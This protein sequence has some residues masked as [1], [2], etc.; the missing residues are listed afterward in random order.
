MNI[1]QLRET[2]DKEYSRLRRLQEADENGNVKCISCTKVTNWR[3]MTV[4]HYIKRNYYSVRYYECNVNP[5]CWSCQVLEES[6]C[7]VT[8]KKHAQGL[9]EKY[10]DHILNTLGKLKRN[11]AHYSKKDYEDMIKSFRAEIRKLKKQKYGIS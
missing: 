7:Q 11:H 4:G 2:A 3:Y 9:I 5:Q 1:S 6:D 8:Q 10:G